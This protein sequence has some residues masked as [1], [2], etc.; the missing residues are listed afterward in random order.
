MAARRFVAAVMVAGMSTGLFATA[1]D[2][3][4][5]NWGQ[6]V[7]TCNQAGCYPGGTTRGAYVLQQASDGQGPGYGWEI[8][9]LALP[10]N[11]DPLPFR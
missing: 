11:S 3:A 2:A 10:G 7:K 8:H 9:N 5:V 4:P 6:E 1:A